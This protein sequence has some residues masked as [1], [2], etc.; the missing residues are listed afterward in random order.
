M[1]GTWRR[2]NREAT[3]TVAMEGGSMEEGLKRKLFP[4]LGETDL[5]RVQDKRANIDIDEVALGKVFKNFLGSAE[6]AAQ[7]HRGQ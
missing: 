6:V 5:N 2:L 3:T 1:R 4:P 7:P